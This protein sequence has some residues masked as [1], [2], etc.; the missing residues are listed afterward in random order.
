MDMFKEKIITFISSLLITISIAIY[1]NIFNS[2]SS[3]VV[4][5]L[6]C[7]IYFGINKLSLIKNYKYKTISSWLALLFSLFQVIGYEIVSNEVLHFKIEIIVYIIAYFIIFRLLLIR[8]INYLVDYKNSNVLNKDSKKIFIFSMI[9][10]FVAWIPYFVL[11]YPGIYTTDSFNQLR[12]IYNV[13]PADNHHPYIVTQFIGLF[14]KVGRLFGL[15]MYSVYLYVLF[16]SLVCLLTFG[17]SIYFLHKRNINKYVLIGL[18]LLYALYPIYPI[19][20]LTMWKDIPFAF[21]MFWFVLITFDLIENN[22]LFLKNKFKVISLVFVIFL[23][24]ITRN[25]GLYVMILTLPF[26]LLF[27]KQ[28]RLKLLMIFA[29]PIISTIILIGPVY[30]ALNVIP[31]KSGEA[32]GVQLQQLARIV[33]YDDLT[34]DQNEKL[35]KYFLIDSSKPTKIDLSKTTSVSNINSLEGLGE[36]YKP[37]LSDP[38]KAVFNLDYYKKNVLGFHQLW[39][40]IA[41]DHPK[42]ALEATLRGSVGYYYPD[43]QYWII[44][45]WREQASYT[46]SDKLIKYKFHKQSD[47]FSAFINDVIDLPIVNTLFSRGFV[48]WSV[49]TLLFV[50]PLRYRK[51]YLVPILSIMFVILTAMASPVAGEY[52]YVYSGFVTLPFLLSYIFTTIKNKKTN[53]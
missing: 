8:I 9:I 37:I 19:Y 28:F 31:A 20:S 23:C 52:R 34:P 16:Q 6:F 11:Y 46:K 7:L 4:I 15:G 45:E 36:V 42:I 53:K 51:E 3:F 29:I 30:N 26:I 12:I 39:A 10:I 43:F 35:A 22:E 17:Y 24:A 1:A 33:K 41:L 50:Y 38:V 5:I 2:K 47:K 48:T 40:E 44:F 18:L 21:S 13:L 49:I 25:N 27:D 14:V 32:L